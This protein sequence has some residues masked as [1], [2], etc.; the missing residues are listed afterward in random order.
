M[1]KI[2]SINDGLEH[3]R[4]LIPWDHLDKFLSHLYIL[5]VL[6]PQRQTIQQMLGFDCFL[7][8]W[9]LVQ[10]CIYIINVI[11]GLG[12][13]FT[14][15]S[16]QK[17]KSHT[18]WRSPLSTPIHL[19]FL[20]IKENQQISF[21]QQMHGT[22]HKGKVYLESHLTFTNIVVSFARANTKLFNLKKEIL[23]YFSRQKPATII[24][25][26][27]LWWPNNIISARVTKLFTKNIFVVVIQ[28]LL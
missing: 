11:L 20:S 17:Q 26:T 22:I 7:S 9:E 23:H 6:T 1:D 4:L 19:S 21:R 28:N 10:T 14:N 15:W 25:P 16:Y 8:F 27:H 13:C 3:D 24:F 5:H 12:V 2:Y 18:T